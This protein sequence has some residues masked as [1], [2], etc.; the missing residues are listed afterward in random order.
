MNAPTARD[1]YDSADPAR[2]G[3]DEMPEQERV[4]TDWLA[5][6][7]SDGP[8]LELG[9][10]HGT[11][12]RVAPHYVGI[13]LAFT[14]LLAT[15]G[16]SVQGDMERLPFRDGSIA[17][18]F[19]WAAIE[20]VPHPERVFVEIERVLRPGG[21]ALL[22]PAWHCRPWAAEGLEFR[23]YAS[24]SRGAK[25]RKSLIPL[26]NSIAWRALFEIPRRVVAEL[27]A[28][29]RKPPF[30]YHRLKP[31]LRE[32]VGTDC[33]AFTSMDPHTAIL[34]FR[35]RGWEVPSHPTRAARMLVRNGAIVVRKPS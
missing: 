31:N 26:R 17:F 2:W 9:C 13:D 35:G 32:Y 3:R 11:L 14:P 10:G 8:V 34:Y 15:R 21:T 18:V 16:K 1:F 25:I 29:L 12:A 28:V 27:A 5:R 23:E 19:S 24:L 6:S 7:A 4:T 20:H 30:S 33:D 22:A